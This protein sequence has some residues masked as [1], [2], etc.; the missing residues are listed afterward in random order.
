[1]CYV[2]IFAHFLSDQHLASTKIG[3]TKIE[4]WQGVDS[5]SVYKWKG[6]PMEASIGQTDTFAQFDPGAPIENF[7]E[8]I[9][10]KMAKNVNKN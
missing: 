3:L 9:I 5:F 6:N 10:R 4:V 7:E 1:M 8:D 2:A